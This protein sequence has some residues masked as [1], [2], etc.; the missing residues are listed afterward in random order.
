MSLCLCLALILPGC[1][2]RTQ[3]DMDVNGTSDESGQSDRM[4]QGRASGGP[5]GGSIWPEIART[6]LQTGMGFLHH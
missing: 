5:S 1:A 4:Q 3:P 6:A 2:Q